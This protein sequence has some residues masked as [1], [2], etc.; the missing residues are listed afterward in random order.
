MILEISSAF[1]GAFFAFCFFMI[2]QYWLASSQK[3]KE[4][5]SYLDALQE[6]IAT[7]IYYFET[8]LQV[9]NLLAGMSPI[10]ITLNEFSIF[11]IEN[12]VYQKL[13]GY[14]VSES[15]IKFIVHL[16]VLNES[17]GVINKWLGELSSLSRVA[18]LEKREDVFKDTMGNNTTELKEKVEK[19]RE[20][21][22]AT[23]A[24]ISTLNAE[25]EFTKRY[26]QSP[27]WKKWYIL[28]KMKSLPDYRSKQIAKMV[29]QLNTI[30]NGS[31]S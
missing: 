9:C 22:V 4:T 26:I 20:Q 3:N 7:Q 5:S 14:Q 15:I 13:T 27:F 28:I 19:V 24:K 23:K 11:P 2:G 6:Y 31:T 18:M 21:I 29:V 17:M 16:R 30:P 10:S 1:L 12:A 8:N 25:I